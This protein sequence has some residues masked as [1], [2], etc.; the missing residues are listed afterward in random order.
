MK[1]KF[2]LFGPLSRSGAQKLIWINIL[3]RLAIEEIARNL[4][5][6]TR[7]MAGPVDTNL[8]FQVEQVAKKSKTTLSIDLH[9][10]DQN[11]ITESREETL[12]SALWFGNGQR[13]KSGH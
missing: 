8:L 3:K 5:A 12:N 11:L 9:V 7:Y 4:N 1:V 6:L 13:S 10:W 2:D